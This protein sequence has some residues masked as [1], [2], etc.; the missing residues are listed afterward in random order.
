MVIDAFIE[1]YLTRLCIL[2]VLSSLLL[3]GRSLVI[4]VDFG[5][6][7]SILAIL[8]QPLNVVVLNGLAKRDSR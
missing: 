2:Y 3:D 4:I 7:F 5:V 6:G 8:I 1:L